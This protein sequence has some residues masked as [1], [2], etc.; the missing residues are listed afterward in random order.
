M[1]ENGGKNTKKRMQCVDWGEYSPQVEEMLFI[2]KKTCF[3]KIIVYL[4]SVTREKSPSKEVH[5]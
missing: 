2:A 5:R 3:L 4:H 1:N